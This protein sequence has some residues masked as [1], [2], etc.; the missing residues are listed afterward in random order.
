MWGGLYGLSKIKVRGRWNPYK[1]K[2]QCGY[3][4]ERTLNL[5]DIAAA[6]QKDEEQLEENVDYVQVYMPCEEKNGYAYIAPQVEGLTYPDWFGNKVERKGENIKIYY[7]GEEGKEIEV[8]DR[9]W[10]QQ[11]KIR[12]NMEDAELQINNFENFEINN[13][14]ADE[15]EYHIRNNIYEYQWKNCNVS[16]VLSSSNFNNL[17]TDNVINLCYH[18]LDFNSNKRLLFLNRKVYNINY[19]GAQNPVQSFYLPVIKK[20]ND[21]YTIVYKLNGEVIQLTTPKTKQPTYTIDK[22]YTLHFFDNEGHPHIALDLLTEPIIEKV[23]N[24]TAI[25]YNLTYVDTE[26][27]TYINLNQKPE[28]APVIRKYIIHY[29][30]TSIAD[31]EADNDMEP[32]IYE[33]M[34][35][36][37]YEDLNGVLHPVTR[38]LNKPDYYITEE[39]NWQWQSKIE[40]HT[41]V[42]CSTIDY[43]GD[44]QII[45]QQIPLG[46]FYIVE[47]QN[48]DTSTISNFIDPMNNGLKDRKVFEKFE[49]LIAD[50]KFA[51]DVNKNIKS[52]NL[53]LLPEYSKT[54]ITIYYNPKTMKPYE[55]NDYYFKKANGTVLEKGNYA[56]I[57]KGEQYYKW[58][59]TIAEPGV[60]LGQTVTLNKWNFPFNFK[61]VGETYIRNRYAEDYHY[62]IE[63]D[64]CAILDN[65]NINLA[66]AGEPTVV[67][68]KMKA[69]TNYNGDIGRLTIYKQED[70]W[71]E[72][73]DERIPEEQNNMLRKGRKLN[74]RR[75]ALRDA[76]AEQVAEIPQQKKY[77]PLDVLERVEDLPISDLYEIKVLHPQI[78][79]IF[80][81][82]QDCA[83]PVVTGQDYTYL[84][85]VTPENEDWEDM[86]Y[87]D[88]YEQIKDELE[89]ED[90][91]IAKVDDEGIIRGFVNDEELISADFMNE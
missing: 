7:Q 15:G 33:G 25:C 24:G 43:N 29:D 78:N 21:S 44:E 6:L 80:C 3:T 70:S 73:K 81:L 56:I 42:S 57:E 41:T 71:V 68:I 61:L 84:R 46:L 36:F 72:P 64:N 19:E 16:L 51:I 30:D 65:I 27:H 35:S 89:K 86:F 69:L 38:L 48:L 39:E 13:L 50:R 77:L 28:T 22:R 32:I 76:A 75:A 62:Q 88:Y 49:N 74:A 4:L 53:S 83:V 34:Y 60:S 31:I 17:A 26:T 23:I 52:Y 9:K 40:L 82:D 54:N 47:D 8:F 10:F 59:R 11:G 90:L 14:Y 79:T 91:L 87:M 66:S 1:Y 58:T 67:N 5:S 85:L 18:N 37:D 55:A 45:S 2:N 12:T 63:L 20:S